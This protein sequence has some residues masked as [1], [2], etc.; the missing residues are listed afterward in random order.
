M[1]NLEKGDEMESTWKEILEEKSTEIKC[2]C[3]VNRESKKNKP[4]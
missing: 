4:T 1:E 3:N 2:K